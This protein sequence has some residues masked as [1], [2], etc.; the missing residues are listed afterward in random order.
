MVIG[1][2]LDVFDV[3][4]YR[5]R[6]FMLRSGTVQAQDFGQFLILE[7]SDQFRVS[8]GTKLSFVV[9]F[10]FFRM[11]FKIFPRAF[12]PGGDGDSFIAVFFQ[13][14]IRDLS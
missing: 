2:G 13:D 8:H 9:S 12:E 1:I 14:L 4:F 10:G 3:P 7:I 5:F 11:L 6:N